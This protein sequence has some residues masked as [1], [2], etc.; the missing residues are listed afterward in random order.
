ME[1]GGRGPSGLVGEGNKFRVASLLNKGSRIPISFEL[2]CLFCHGTQCKMRIAAQFLTWLLLL[3]AINLPFRAEGMVDFSQM[4]HLSGI[5]DAD[6][7]LVLV[8]DPS[9]DLLIKRQ[10]RTQSSQPW[11][12]RPD[13]HDDQLTPCKIAVVLDDR[14]QRA[15]F[16]RLYNQFTPAGLTAGHQ[17]SRAPPGMPI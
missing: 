15:T 11:L 9:S 13:G 2:N 8:S 17:Y 5:S 7:T 14:S 12:D 16:V 1:H 3:L 6:Q 4:D 10:N